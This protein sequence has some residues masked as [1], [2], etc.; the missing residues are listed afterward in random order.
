M[1]LES[2]LNMMP[3]ATKG[4]SV[5]EE[6]EK[7]KQEKIDKLGSLLHDEWRQGFK[8]SKPDD[9]DRFKPIKDEKVAE[10]YEK[11][12]TE[13]GSIVVDRNNKNE[14]V[15]QVRQ[16]KDGKVAIADDGKIY[17]DILNSSYSELSDDWKGENKFSAEVAMDE[18]YKAID[19]G[20]TLDDDFIESA[21]SVIHDKWME[22]NS[23]AKEQ[24]PELFVPYNELS[25]EEKE[26][27]RVIIK[28]AI[29]IFQEK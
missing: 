6:K 27:D 2:K 13:P 12:C 25:E 21:S 10:S 17:L 23:W 24:Q 8:K 3:Q 22:R 5:D 18:I 16:S 29:N 20:A 7:Q 28:K 11:L 9:P 26:K 14:R 15:I 1:G 19:N 4:S